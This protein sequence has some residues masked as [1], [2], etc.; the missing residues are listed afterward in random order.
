MKFDN[1][2]KPIALVTYAILAYFLIN[3]IGAVIKSIQFILSLFSPVFIGIGLAFVLNL[4]MKF[5]EV[6]ILDKLFNKK[7]LKKFVNLKRPFGMAFTYISA[8]AIVA[9]VINFIIPQLT[10]SIKALTNS[11]PEYIAQLGTY[12]QGITSSYDF[13]KDLWTQFV[14]NLDKVIS[15]ASQ[16]INFAVP[17]LVNLTKGLTS[18]VINIFLGFVFSIYM[19][20]SKEKLIKMLK[21]VVYVTFE[22]NTANRICEIAGNANK[23]FGSFI[24]GQ[25]IESTILG[26]L[27]FIGMSI[28]RMPYAPLVSL[29]V[30]ISSLVPVLGTYVGVIISAFLILLESPIMALWFVIFIIILQQI[31]GNL[32]YPKVVGNAIGLSGIWVLLAVTVGGSLFGVLGILLGVPVMA[33]IYSLFKEYTNNK[34]K[35]MEIEIE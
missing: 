18:V 34:L 12:F 16:I 14:N 11:F 3:N 1:L 22:K 28:I 13:T 19:L 23:V 25:I 21:K 33:V 30:G 26:I 35:K 10:T 6:K 15:N 20:F 7:K 31:E 29:I 2:R 27:C 32:I 9:I 17:Q 5:Y 8:A 4:M 24:G